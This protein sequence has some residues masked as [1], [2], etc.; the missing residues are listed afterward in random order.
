MKN[1][2]K[3]AEA[4]NMNSFTGF[5]NS[6]ATSMTCKDTE[7]W[8]VFVCYSKQ[9]FESNVYHNGKNNNNRSGKTPALQANIRIVNLWIS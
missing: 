6:V 5:S 3:V 9:T 4:L 2:N 7:M 8:S 1:L